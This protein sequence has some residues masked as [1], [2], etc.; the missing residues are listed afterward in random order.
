MKTI[1]CN[2]GKDIKVQVVKNGENKGRE[3]AVCN[4][5]ERWHWLDMPLCEVCHEERLF[6]ARCKQGDN[7]NRKFVACPNRCKGQFKWLDAERGE[8]SP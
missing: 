4:F 5:C 2:C 1:N 3:F 8:D 7:L 6:T